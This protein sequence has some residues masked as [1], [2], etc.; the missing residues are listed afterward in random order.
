MSNTPNPILTLQ[1]HV[2]DLLAADPYFSGVKIYTE[3]V[4]DL[5]Q[6]I[7]LAIDELGFF[8]VV[9]TARGAAAPGAHPRPL[10]MVETLTIT[11]S[12]NPLLEPGSHPTAL[13]AVPEV[14]RLLHGAPG[15]AGHSQGGS[16]LRV[17]GH[18]YAAEAPEGLSVQQVHLETT[19]N[20]LTIHS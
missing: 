2:A 3:L 10:R 17:T 16:Y 9:T 6:Q 18:E 20:F 19:I 5:E 11:I 13:D 12:A 7:T 4:A 8:V 1:Q 15:P 14:I